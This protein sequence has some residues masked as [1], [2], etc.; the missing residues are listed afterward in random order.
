VA[1]VI[2]EFEKPEAGPVAEANAAF[3]VRACNA[4][5]ALVEALDKANQRI[6]QLCS[7]VNTLSICAG[8]TP[9]KVTL[10]DWVD[11][12]RAALKLAKEG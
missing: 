9:R 12:I 6:E 3:I 2:G 4:H 10:G 11:D 7:T 5:D 1:A 8:G